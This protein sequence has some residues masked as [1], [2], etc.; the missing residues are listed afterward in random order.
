MLHDANRRMRLEFIW[1]PGDV[2]RVITITRMFF[3]AKLDSY[4]AD[5]WKEIGKL[6]GLAKTKSQ[7]RPRIFHCRVQEVGGDDLIER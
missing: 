1:R 2:D 4:R 5:F 3:V 6:T 7:L